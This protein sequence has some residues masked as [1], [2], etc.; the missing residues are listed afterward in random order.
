MTDQDLVRSLSNGLKVLESFADAEAAVTLSEVAKRTTLSRATARR[1]LHT[2][3]HLGYAIT[4]GR[5]FTLTPKVLS[6]GL[7]F[8][9]NNNLKDFIQPALQTL[10]AQLNES[11]SASILVNDEIIYIARVHT[12]RIMR[13]DLDVGTRLPAFATSMGR[14]LLSDLEDQ[15]LRRTLEDF[16]RPQLTQATITEVDK[17][18]AIIQKAHTD[19]YAIVD[20]ELEAGLRSVSAPIRHPE[21]GIIAA[22]NVSVSAGLE[23][24]EKSLHRVLPHLRKTAT[25]VSEAVLAWERK[26]GN[27]HSTHESV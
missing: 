19:G 12:R 2:L 21:R 10:S 20:Q 14:V 15:E 18:T 22:L 11:C 5:Y 25:T 17:L 23:P 24:A 6:L 8:R 16:E 1:M 27:P 4:D 7:G 3:V 26:A 13:M 9:P